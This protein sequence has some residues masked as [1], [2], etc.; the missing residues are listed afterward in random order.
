M[1]HY[2]LIMLFLLPLGEREPSVALTDWRVLPESTV[3][4]KIK[5]FGVN[6][7]G[8]LGGLEASIQFSPDDLDN[9]SIEATL[10][11]STI[12]TGIVARDKHLRKE[13]YF[14]VEKF[15]KIRMRSSSLAKKA[16]KQF[17][18]IFDLSIKGSTQKVTF[19]FEFTQ[20]GDAGRFIGEFTIN[21]RDFEIGGGSLVL[22]NQVSIQLNVLCQAK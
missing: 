13:D 9:S 3:S 6:V 19:P 17:E 21:R 4:F 2:L 5:N 18:A 11:A 16:D 8:T 14:H 15:P 7:N 1:Q 12:N 10:D 22:G 20:E